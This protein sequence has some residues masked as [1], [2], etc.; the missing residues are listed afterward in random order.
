MILMIVVD[1][2]DENGVDINDYVTV[3]PVVPAVA[4]TIV[5]TDVNV[6]VVNDL[7]SLPNLSSLSAFPHDLN[8]NTPFSPWHPLPPAPSSSPSQPEPPPHPPHPPPAVSGALWDKCWQGATPHAPLSS[9]SFPYH[10]CSLHIFSLSLYSSLFVSSC[11]SPNPLVSSFFPSSSLLYFRR[12]SLSYHPSPLSSSHIYFSRLPFSSS[13]RLSF[14][15]PP[16]L[17]LSS[18]SF[19]LHPPPPLSLSS[20]SSLLPP[21]SLADHP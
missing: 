6:N 13:S 3:A 10:R 19:L 20:P 9:L 17:S 12:S 2:H 14:S 16:Q 5:D 15:P 7:Y 11:S 21:S 8:D 4:D 18:P 1:D